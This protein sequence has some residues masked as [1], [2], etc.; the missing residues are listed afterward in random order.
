MVIKDTIDLKDQIKTFAEKEGM[1]F[2][3]LAVKAGMSEKGLHNKFRRDSLTVKDLI[4]L[5]ACLGK[6]LDIKDIDK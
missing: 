1:T 6:A 2:K 5:L 3:E 4:K